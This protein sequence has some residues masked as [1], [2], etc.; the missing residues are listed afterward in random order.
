MKF[1]SLDLYT[2]LGLAAGVI[3]LALM[4]TGLVSVFNAST[5]EACVTCSTL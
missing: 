1:T 2:L 3:A 5:L 4:V